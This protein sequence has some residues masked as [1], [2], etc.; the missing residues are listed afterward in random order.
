LLNGGTERHTKQGLAEMFAERQLGYRTNVARDFATLSMGALKDDL[1]DAMGLMAELLTE[2][3]FPEDELKIF[4]DRA[5]AELAHETATQAGA[6]G[7][8]VRRLIFGATHDY[9]RH[10]GDEASLASITRGAIF[11]RCRGW[12]D[13][14]QATLVIVGDLSLD[15]AVELAGSAFGHWSG[16][17]PDAVRA[18]SLWAPERGRYFIDHPGGSQSALHIALAA[19]GVRPG[20]EARSM[21]NLLF[22]GSFG[23]RLNANLRERRGWTYGISSGFS[24]RPQ[25]GAFRIQTQ[26]QADKTLAA[27]DEIEAEL[28]GLGQDRPIT[29]EEIEKARD[30]LLVSLPTRWAGNKPILDA[31][32]DRIVLKLPDDHHD[33][34]E[35][36]IRKVGRDDVEAV[37]SMVGNPEDYSWVIAGDAAKVAPEGF[38]RIDADGNR[39]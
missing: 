24:I 29:N 31:L 15:E 4:L 27:L 18:A 11:D 28:V 33:G 22:G 38:E 9:G 7:K 17:G 36:R 20:N 8:A 34:I 2:P 1:G 16:A 39:L 3:L 10:G 13:P 19:E 5:S 37:V 30:A 14:S 25:L 21:F 26:V 23:S 12:F 32:V 35:D 6:A